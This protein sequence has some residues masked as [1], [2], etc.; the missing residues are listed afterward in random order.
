MS[1]ESLTWNAWLSWALHQAVRCWQ[2]AA[3]SLMSSVLQDQYVMLT[4]IVLLT[5]IGAPMWSVLQT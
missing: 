2:Q 3:W 1:S 5:L 4:L